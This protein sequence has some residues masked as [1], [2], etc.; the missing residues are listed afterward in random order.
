MFSDIER[1][2]DNQAVPKVLAF[3][4]EAS[5]LYFNVEHVRDEVWRKI[6]SIPDPIGLVVCDLSI[7]PLVDIAGARMLK[8]LQKDLQ[9]SGIRLRLVAAHALARDILRAEGLEESVGYFG[10]RITVADVV[11]EFQADPASAPSA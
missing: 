1:N 7:S 3:R 11:D 8:G 4:V 9:A 2:P 10:R 5:L 6:R